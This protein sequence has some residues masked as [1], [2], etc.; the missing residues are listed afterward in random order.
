MATTTWWAGSRAA[1]RNVIGGNGLAPLFS[2]HGIKVTGDKSNTIIG[3]HVGV[4][5]AGLSSVPN[6][7]N[8]IQIDGSDNVVGGSAAGQR[9]VISGNDTFG[10]GLGGRRQSEH[11]QGQLHR[12][13]IRRLDGHPPGRRRLAAGQLRQRHRRARPQARAT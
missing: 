2:T 1:D 11:D 5:R 13:R 7:T 3:N 4:D 10:I 12:G 8:G 9:N 6:L